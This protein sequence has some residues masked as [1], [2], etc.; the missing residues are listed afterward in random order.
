MGITM[1][2]AELHPENTGN[3]QDVHLAAD[4]ERNP[5]AT[6]QRGSSTVWRYLLSTPLICIAI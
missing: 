1:S 4:L 6:M 3:P 5:A 2:S